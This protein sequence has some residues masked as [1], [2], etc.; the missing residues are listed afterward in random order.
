[1]APFFTGLAKNLGGYGFSRRRNDLNRIVPVRFYIELFGGKGSNYEINSNGSPPSSDPG[2]Q[3]GN[4]GY[5]KLDMTVPS[6]HIITTTSYSGGSNYVQGGSGV[7]FAIDGDWMA[8]VGGGGGASGA[9][10]FQQGNPPALTILGTGPAGG[11]GQGGYSG[12]GTGATGGNSTPSTTILNPNPYTERSFSGGSG[13]GG[14][15]GGAGGGTNGGSG[16][17]ANIRIEHDQGILSGFLTVNPEIKMTY[18]THSN[19][20]ST[21]ATVKI[22]NYSSGGFANYPTSATIPV[23]VI[24]NL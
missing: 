11:A 21:G 5:T 15:N 23:S 17:T 14:A 22:T 19:G 8:I 24:K 1:M 12:T 16:G 20:T 18:V 6:S 10:E 9:Y 13:G 2:R 7:G 3:G 4:G